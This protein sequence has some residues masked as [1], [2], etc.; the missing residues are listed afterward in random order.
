MK[1]VL[2]LLVLAFALTTGNLLAQSYL[3]VISYNVR[4]SF[5]YASLNVWPL[6][7]GASERLLQLERPPLL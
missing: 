2:L 6:P 4:L 5:A 3:K 1:R 7:R